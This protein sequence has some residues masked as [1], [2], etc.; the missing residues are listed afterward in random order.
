[1]TSHGSKGRRTVATGRVYAAI[2]RSVRPYVARRSN[3]GAITRRARRYAMVTT[4]YKSTPPLEGVG[5]VVRH[6][7]S[8]TVVPVVFH[9]RAEPSVRAAV[10]ADGVVLRS[11]QAPITRRQSSLAE[12]LRTASRHAGSRR[13]ASGRRDAEPRLAREGDVAAG[14]RDPGERVVGEER[15][16][17]EVRAVQQRREVCRGRD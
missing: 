2:L 4:D 8:W 10:S 13:A 14:D 3:P 1:M 16:A 6:G 5:E 12:H 17:V 9:A 7:P 11:L 15:R